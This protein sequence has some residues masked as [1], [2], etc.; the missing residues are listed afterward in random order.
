MGDDDD[1]VVVV[2]GGGEGE[3]VDLDDNRSD[4]RMMSQAMTKALVDDGDDPAVNPHELYWGGC[5][6]ATEIEATALSEVNGWLKRKG[7]ASLEER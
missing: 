4:D 1:D 7:Q 2:D 5:G 3:T 6:D